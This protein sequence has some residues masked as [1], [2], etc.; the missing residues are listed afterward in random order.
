M[1]LCLVTIQVRRTD[2]QSRSQNLHRQCWNYG[3][4]FRQMRVL[5][6]QAANNYKCVR[7]IIAKTAFLP[8]PA[9]LAPPP[10]SLGLN[11]SLL[12]ESERENSQE[13]LITSVGRQSEDQRG[14]RSTQSMFPHTKL[15]RYYVSFQW[16]VPPKQKTSTSRGRSLKVADSML[17]KMSF[18]TLCARLLKRTRENR[19]KWPK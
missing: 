4:C 1:L 14:W 10:R 18:E 7:A 16:A 3:C 12:S 17:V 2:R 8:G 15:G 5:R 9:L 13:T 11:T 6:K 19:D